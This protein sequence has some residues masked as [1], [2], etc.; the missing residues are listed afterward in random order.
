VTEPRGPIDWARQ[1]AAEREAAASYDKAFDVPPPDEAAPYIRERLAVRR[2]QP[3]RYTADTITDPAL[4]QLYAERDAN[5]RRALAY[6]QAWLAAEQ[7]AE[8]AETAI[9][10]VRKLAADMRTWASPR[11]LANHYADSVETALDESKEPRP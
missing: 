4:D 8:Q 7:R 5:E 2:E 9:A 1:Q 11:G 3:I 10:R 6:G